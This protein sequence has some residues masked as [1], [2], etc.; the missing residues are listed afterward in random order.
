M[1]AGKEDSSHVGSHELYPET[2]VHPGIVVHV[3]EDPEGY[4]TRPAILQTRRPVIE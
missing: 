4:A 3:C 2:A 1:C